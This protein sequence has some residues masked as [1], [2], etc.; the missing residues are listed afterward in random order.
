MNLIKDAFHINSNDAEVIYNLIELYILE[1]KYKQ[2]KDMIRYFYKHREKLQTI[3]KAMDFY[4]QK[5]SLFEK[6][7]TTQHM[8]KK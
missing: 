1:H 5:I 2:A 3:D 8:F 7:I 6:F 4:D